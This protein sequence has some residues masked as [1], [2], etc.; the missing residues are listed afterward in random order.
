MA[1]G[2]RKNLHSG[3]GIRLGLVVVGSLP[4]CYLAT[5]KNAQ[6][7][8]GYSSA[9]GSSV[10]ACTEILAASAASALVV[11]TRT[12]VRTDKKAPLL[13]F[14]CK[15]L[16]FLKPIRL[17]KASLPVLKIV[18]VL[19]VVKAGQHRKYV[20]CKFSVFK[21]NANRYFAHNLNS[22]IGDNWLI[23][24]LPHA[25]QVPP[26]AQASRQVLAFYR[27]GGGFHSN[28][29]KISTSF[30]ETRRVCEAA[31]QLGSKGTKKSR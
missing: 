22:R 8:P 11:C 10:S 26:L 25:T 19:A 31:L 2:C 3:A 21:K 28:N 23:W 6:L 4:C 7:A 5:Y 13:L 29:F 16:K 15:C 17:I 27:C 24:V 9:I 12:I 14:G 20:V 18:A 30:C 1:P